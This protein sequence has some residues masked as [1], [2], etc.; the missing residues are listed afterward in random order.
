MPILS[1]TAHYATVAWLG[2]VRDQDDDIGAEA[3]EALTLDWGGPVGDVHHGVTRPSCVRVRGQYKKG[4][5]IRNVRQ[6]SIVSAEELGEI[7]RRLD[8]PAVRPEWLGATVVLEGLTDFTRITPGARLI[9]GGPSDDGPSIVIDM[10]NAPCHLPAAE[11]EKRHPG[12]GKAFPQKARNLRGVTAWVERPGTLGLG[13][14]RTDL[15]IVDSYG[16]K[17][18]VLTGSGE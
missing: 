14:F 18:L 5:E 6:L 1:P 15:D 2:L 11:I 8:I 9:A 17:R 4:T 16:A 12:H 10:E 7:A 13:N 3:V